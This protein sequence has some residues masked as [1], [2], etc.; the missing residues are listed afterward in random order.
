MHQTVLDARGP[1]P[2]P[3]P[4]APAVQSQPWAPIQ[5]GRLCRGDSAHRVQVRT[6]SGKMG[7]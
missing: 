7:I 3:N 1:E 5:T 6:I 4:G 2:A